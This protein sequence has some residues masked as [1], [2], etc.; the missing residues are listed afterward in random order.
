MSLGIG[1]MLDM[2]VGNSEDSQSAHKAIGKTIA[3]LKLKDDRL[4]ISFD[5][6]S[7][8]EIEDHGQSCCETRYMRT[9][10]DLSGFVGSKLVALEIRQ[11]PDVNDGDGYGTHE[12][13]FLAVKTGGGDLVLETHNEHNGYYGGFAVRAEYFEA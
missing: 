7:R 9:D 2:L 12:V 4:I 6:A 1:V 11:A 3:G 5:D 10:D 8:L 13:Q